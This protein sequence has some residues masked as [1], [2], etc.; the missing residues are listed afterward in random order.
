MAGELVRVLLLAVDHLMR[1]ERL[2]LLSKRQGEE[3]PRIDEF[4]TAGSTVRG[5][6]DAGNRQVSYLPFLGATATSSW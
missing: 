2:L 1:V 5:E 6:E 3:D 4:E